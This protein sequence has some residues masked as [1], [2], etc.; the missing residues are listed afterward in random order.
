MTDVRYFVDDSC[1][2]EFQDFADDFFWEM[3]PLLGDGPTGDFHAFWMVKDCKVIKSIEFGWK[4][5]QSE[6]G[7]IRSTTDRISIHNSNPFRIKLTFTFTFNP[8]NRIEQ[9][10]NPNSDIET[11]PKNRT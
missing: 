11:I 3:G 1:A 7:K 8:L 4:N 5:V 2:D 6:L 10:S 9:R